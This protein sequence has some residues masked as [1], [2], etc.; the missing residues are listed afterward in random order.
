MKMRWK[1]SEVTE[2]WREQGGR[3]DDGRESRH[4]DAIIVVLP[5]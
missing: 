4:G 3:S 2:G 1:P 5:G